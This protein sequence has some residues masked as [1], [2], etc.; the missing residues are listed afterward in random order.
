[1][2]RYFGTDGF[3]GEAGTVLTA[4]H[5]Y[6]IGRF[7]GWYYRKEDGTRAR[8]VVGKDT[9]R[10]SYMFE[11]A[12]AAGLTASGADAYMLHV[13]TTPSVSHV[14]RMD[15]F[16]CGVMISASHNSFGDNGIKLVNRNGEKM[17]DEVQNR[18]EDYLDGARAELGIPGADIPFAVGANIGQII[19]YS[20]GRNR[21]VAYLIS[22][23]MHSYK[24][25]RVGL[26][27]ANGASWML[28]KSVFEALGAKTYTINTE[29]NGININEGAGSTHIEGLVSFVKENHLDVGFAFDG[30]ADRC[31]A[32]DENGN[33]VTGDH[34]LYIFAN[35]LKRKGQLV[36]NT[37]VTTI[38]SNLGLYRALDAVGIDYVQTKVG[39]RYVYENMLETGN[40]VGGEQS[41][42]IILSKYATTGDGI[43][44]AIQVMETM[45]AR[46]LPLSKLAE[47]VTMF[48]QVLKNI[49]VEN[50]A[51][52]KANAN[53]QAAVEAVAEELGKSG[54]ILLRES[55]TEPV[56][57]VMVEAK[58]EL[59]C[60]QMVD[61]V[62]E[63]IINEG[64][65]PKAG[66]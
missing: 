25:V 60:E 21:Y 10:S 4:D 62:I 51:A 41:G 6:R 9:R 33:V 35:E 11:Y 3:R 37:L 55:G 13:T 54:R 23:A 19:D 57:R 44:T 17:E 66:K 47:P 28:A 8:V 50:K 34:I 22:V 48:P 27:C 39:D 40:C 59:L 63:V 45:M 5:A 20:A 12:I 56:I 58:T 36:N 64:L 49:R 43:L 61:R 29:P 26:D 53:V 24:G 14:T 1:M 15:D 31:L 2:G 42:H 18:I 52:V 7:L 32:V 16:D 46:K 38:M 65:A 30:D